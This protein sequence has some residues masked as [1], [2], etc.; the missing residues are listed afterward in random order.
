MGG[1]LGLFFGCDMNNTPQYS[2]S[3]T[4]LCKI[5]VGL[6][7]FFRVWFFGVVGD[8]VFFFCLE[9]VDYSERGSER[10]M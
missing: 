8:L 10:R 6:E 2:F 4:F 5:K 1:E 9:K 7:I 3:L